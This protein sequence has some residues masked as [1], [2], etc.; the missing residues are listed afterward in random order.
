[1]QIPFPLLHLYVRPSARTHQK[2]AL[3]DSM[4]CSC[5]DGQKQVFCNHSEYFQKQWLV[6][7]V[8]SFSCPTTMA[9]RQALACPDGQTAVW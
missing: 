1:M 7:F 3:Y 9:A 5:L 8:R 2:Q 6:T 4:A